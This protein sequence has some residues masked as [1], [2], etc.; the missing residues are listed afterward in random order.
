[1]VAKDSQN[2]NAPVVD[3]TK[4]LAIT[5]EVNNGNRAIRSNF[6]PLMEIRPQ[7]WEYWTIRNLND[8][9]PL[10]NQYSQKA[11]DGKSFFPDCARI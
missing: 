6:Q 9:F 11:V 1:M 8:H 7:P 2:G 10:T 3:G 4:V 5:W